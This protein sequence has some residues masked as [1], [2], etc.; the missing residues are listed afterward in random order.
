MFLIHSVDHIVRYFILVSYDYRNNVIKINVL[1]PFHSYYLHD[2]RNLHSIF[3][4]SKTTGLDWVLVKKLN[5]C[6]NLK[7]YL[8]TINK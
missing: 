3:H 6:C 2:G 7:C 5:I 1:N 4:C 8:F